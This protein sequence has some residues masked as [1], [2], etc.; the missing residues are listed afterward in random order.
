LKL[1]DSYGWIEYFSD[2]RLANKYAPYIEDANENNS[3]TPTV[4]L[5][6][7]YRRLKKQKGEQIAL[8]AYAQITR[9]KIVPLDEDLALMAADI[10][11]EKGLAMADAI[12]YSTATLHSAELLTSDK[13]LKDLKGTRFIE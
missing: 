3:V 12:I 8:E 7:V 6:E 5:Y 9:T 4:V 13:D 10:S 1:I 11:L 2:G